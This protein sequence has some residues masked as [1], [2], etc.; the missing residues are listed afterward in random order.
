M[1]KCDVQFGLFD[2]DVVALYNH[3]RSTSDSSSQPT[4]SQPH[5]GIIII[6]IIFLNYLLYF[7]YKS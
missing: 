1:L 6:I 7:C 5:K 4:V 3:P 2:D